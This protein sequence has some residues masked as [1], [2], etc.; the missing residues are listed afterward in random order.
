M[1]LEESTEEETD[2]YIIAQKNL[3]EDKKI[4]VQTLKISLLS[5]LYNIQ[6]TEI[7]FSSFCFSYIYTAISLSPILHF[8]W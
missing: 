4:T 6:L 1:G 2:F 7:F 5:K 8:Y 3:G